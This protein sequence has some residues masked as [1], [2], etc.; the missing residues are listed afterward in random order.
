MTQSRFRQLHRCCV[1]EELHHR[2]TD[3]WKTDVVIVVMVVVL[4]GAYA[5][6]E[7]H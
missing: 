6:F 2:Q 1:E 3:R 4:R 7:P 5:G